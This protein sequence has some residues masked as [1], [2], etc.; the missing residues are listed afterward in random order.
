MS[1]KDILELYDRRK[2]LEETLN[3]PGFADFDPMAYHEYWEE[4]DEITEILESI[5]F[6]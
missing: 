2:E 3:D 1:L 6:E 5:K 4:Y